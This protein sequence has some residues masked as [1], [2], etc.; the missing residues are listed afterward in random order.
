MRPCTFRGVQNRELR[1]WKKTCPEAAK[2]T[3]EKLERQEMI[4]RYHGRIV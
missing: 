1:F 3:V 2:R 4:L